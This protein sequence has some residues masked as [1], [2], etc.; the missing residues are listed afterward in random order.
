[1]LWFEKIHQHA[2]RCSRQYKRSEYE[3]VLALQSV[4][5]KRVYRKMGYASLFYYAVK[6]LKLPEGS[7]Y[8]FI[9]V[10]RKSI[11]MPKITKALEVGDITVSQAKRVLSV[12]QPATQDVWIEK[13]KSLT[14][15]RLE[16]EV[17]KESPHVAVPERIRPVCEDRSRL[18]CGISEVLERKLQRAREI[19]SQ[20]RRRVC[21]LEEV[22]EA[23]ADG[24]LEEHDPIERAK[25]SAVNGTEKLPVVTV[26][27]GI[28]SATR[29]QVILRDYG[30]CAYREASGDRCGSR[31]FLDI[32][33]I[34]PTSRGGTNAL[35]N[36]TLLCKGH[37]RATHEKIILEEKRVGGV[38][39]R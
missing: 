33:H 13:A 22:I 2:V 35:E 3:L 1:M 27:K 11:Q 26:G 8:A 18:E 30:A 37:H 21:S 28:S 15:R 32:H 23:M 4:D 24:F 12:I 34:L 7:A 16:Q 19:L 20:K 38:A 31:Y 36:L 14:Q 29:H 39:P 6:A 10:A 9:N 25:R 17:A 5:A